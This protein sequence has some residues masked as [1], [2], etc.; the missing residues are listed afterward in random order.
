MRLTANA[1]A[2]KPRQT[3]MYVDDASATYIVK[4]KNRKARVDAG[5]IDAIRARLI[6]HE[7]TCHW[8]RMH[9][10]TGRSGLADQSPNANTWADS[11]MNILGWLNRKGRCGLAPVQDVQ[12]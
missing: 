10:P 1:Q 11:I 9:S 2:A 7:L 3:D 5:V 12:A 8:P 4:A 6:V